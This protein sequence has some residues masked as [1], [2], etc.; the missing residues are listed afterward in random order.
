MNKNHIKTGKGKFL[1]NVL[2]TG[3]IPGGAP[4]NSALRTMQTGYEGFVLGAIGKDERVL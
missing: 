4:F 1:R 2:P 3:K